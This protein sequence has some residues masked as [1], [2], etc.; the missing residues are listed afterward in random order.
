MVRL[1]GKQ[2]HTV[3]LSLLWC[4]SFLIF[5]FYHVYPTSMTQFAKKYGLHNGGFPCV[6]Q[7][8]YEYCYLDDEDQGGRV[9]LDDL[10]SKNK[11]ANYMTYQQSRSSWIYMREVVSWPK[12]RG[13]LLQLLIA[14]TM[15][16][17]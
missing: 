3:G 7:N 4:P 2:L 17:L 15:F 11:C 9:E 5:N 13:K 6:N 10:P 1:R 14:S 12:E 16:T 8:G